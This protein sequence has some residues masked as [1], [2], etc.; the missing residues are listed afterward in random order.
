MPK[1]GAAIVA[2]ALAG[3]G[4]AALLIERAPYTGVYRGSSIVV[5][6]TGSDELGLFYL[7]G[8]TVIVAEAT[9]M[10]SAAYVADNDGTPSIPFAA[11]EGSTVI[12]NGAYQYDPS[13]TLTGGGYLLCLYPRD[14]YT[15]LFFEHGCLAEQITLPNI[16]Q[17]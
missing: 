6:D 11:D 2:F 13:K 10:L 7:T 17:P 3:A 4:Q 16:L 1:T 12:I 8:A 9:A 5:R 14:R 15:M